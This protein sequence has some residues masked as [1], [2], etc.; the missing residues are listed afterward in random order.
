MIAISIYEHSNKMLDSFEIWK[1]HLRDGFSIPEIW[2]SVR[3]QNLIVFPR[4]V[5]TSNGSSAFKSAK[6]VWVLSYFTD[7]CY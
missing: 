4:Q 7:T 3:Q 6:Y 1:A 5:D 2:S